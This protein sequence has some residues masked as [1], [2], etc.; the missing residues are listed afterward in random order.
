M[1]VVSIYVILCNSQKKER[2][3]ARRKEMTYTEE[4]IVYMEAEPAHHRA[5]S[6]DNH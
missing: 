3:A 1:L 2:A 4:K 5:D 6:V